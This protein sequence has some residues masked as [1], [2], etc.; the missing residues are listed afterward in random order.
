MRFSRY[1]RLE[2][3]EFLSSDGKE[4]ATAMGHAVDE[5]VQAARA[6]FRDYTQVRDSVNKVAFSPDGDR[7][8]SVSTD[9]YAGVWDVATGEVLLALAGHSGWVNDIAFAP[10]GETVVS[11][12]Q[13]G[14]A[15]V[16]DASTGD[17]LFEY[18]RIPG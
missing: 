13:D 9:G 4:M 3:P 2:P 6:F 7:I 18:G 12:G 10:N 8:A 16:W 14:T 1:A 17:S 15:R 11:A 5:L